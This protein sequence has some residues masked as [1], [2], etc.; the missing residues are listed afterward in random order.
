MEKRRSPPPPR[1][2]AVEIFVVDRKGDAKNLEYGSVHRYSVP[3]FRRAGAGSIL[4][5]PSYMRIGRDY[6]DDKGIVLNDRRDKFKNREKYIFSK[7]EKERSRLLKIRPESVQV[8]A[9]Q[10]VDFVPLQTS[11]GKKR[12]SSVDGESSDSEYV[13]YF[14]E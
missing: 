3:P 13:L 5:M 1:D 8:S 6:G 9:I 11:R 2:E 7:I 14:S 10:E 12:K 4:G